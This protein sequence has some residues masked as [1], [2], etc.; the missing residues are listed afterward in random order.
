MLGKVPR[1]LPKPRDSGG[2]CENELD[3]DGGQYWGDVS[4]LPTRAM[5]IKQYL[6]GQINYQ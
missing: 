4:G 5:K 1:G 2:A 3:K 6:F